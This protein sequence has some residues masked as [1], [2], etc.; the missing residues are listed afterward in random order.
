MRG[1]GMTSYLVKF[2]II[3]GCHRTLEVSALTILDAKKEFERRTGIPQWAV[4]KVTKIK[5][6]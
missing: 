5:S 4:L 6:K 3:R 2:F 1:Q